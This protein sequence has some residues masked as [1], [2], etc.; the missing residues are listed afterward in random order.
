MFLALFRL[1]LRDFGVILP[2]LEQ[3]QQN[4]GPKSSGA[5][6]IFN[7]FG[8]KDIKKQKIKILRNNSKNI[9]NLGIYSENISKNSRIIGFEKISHAK[10]GL[11]IYLFV[12]G[13]IDW[14]LK[15][16]KIWIKW[17]KIKK[18]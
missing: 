6:F 16:S 2:D 18:Y 3:I 12:F 8:V 13:V 17:M 7:F 9:R 11:F 14:S 5:F 4:S 15:N 1:F 10:W